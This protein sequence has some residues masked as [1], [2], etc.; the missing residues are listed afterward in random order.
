MSKGR[1]KRK[2]NSNSSQELSSAVIQ[3]PKKLKDQSAITDHF[4]ATADLSDSASDPQEKM[5][6]ESER[7]RV[8]ERKIDL[9]LS[10][11]DAQKEELE[12]VQGQMHDMRVEWERMRADVE[13]YKKEAERAKEQA[14]EAK[15]VAALALKQVDDLEQYTR[16]NNIRV[17]GVVEQVGE[18]DV[19]CEVKILQLAKEKLK[20]DIRPQDIEA[21][22]RVGKLERPG[23]TSGASGDTSKQKQKP[24]AIIVRFVSR[25]TTQ[26]FLSKRRALKGS[27]MG[28]NEDLTK[29]KLSLL[30]RCQ[31]DPKVDK[32]WTSNG[33]II[34]LGWDNRTRVITKDSELNKLP[35]ATSTPAPSKGRGGGKGRVAQHTTLD[36]IAGSSSKL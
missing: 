11:L 1:R 14:Q 4:M 17:F 31:L 15:E 9:V 2:K 8:L 33:K 5:E 13:K 19:D 34:V 7:E 32:A 16:R 28:I 30:S 36:E 27:G 3:T 29:T 35:V 26:L 24:R 12:R 23:V 10:K 6:R 21:V 20:I 22:H 25:K 18:T